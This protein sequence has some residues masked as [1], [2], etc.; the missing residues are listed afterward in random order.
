MPDLPPIL[1]SRV[2]DRTHGASDIRGIGFRTAD[3]VA[4]KLGN[5]PTAMIRVRACTSIV[6]KYPLA[7][8]NGQ[9]G[10]KR[11]LIGALAGGPLPEV[12]KGKLARNPPPPSTS[13]ERGRGP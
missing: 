5:E 6:A 8:A 4:G 11:E 13:T 10:T 1:G 7:R 3:I 2:N 9:I 12:A